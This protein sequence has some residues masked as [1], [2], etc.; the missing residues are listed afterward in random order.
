MASGR[1]VIENSFDKINSERSIEEQSLDNDAVC[2]RST[3]RYMLQTLNQFRREG[4]EGLC[5]VV[6][7]VQA[8]ASASQRIAAFWL[9]TVS[10]STVCSP[11]A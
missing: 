4:E 2:F 8:K 11:A 6:L 5:D 1:E 3:D 7:E 9:Q 10:I